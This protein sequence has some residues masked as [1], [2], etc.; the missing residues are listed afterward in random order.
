MNE[1]SKVNN[2]TCLPESEILVT[3]L[4]GDPFK[5]IKKESH[6]IFELNQFLK[7]D[8]KLRLFQGVIKFENLFEPKETYIQHYE[9]FFRFITTVAFYENTNTEVIVFKNTHIGQFIRALPLY[10]LESYG[11]KLYFLFRD[12]RAI[13]RSQKKSVGSWGKPMAKHPATLVHEWDNLF[14]SWIYFQKKDNT[15]VMASTYENLVQNF[16]QEL[17][18]IFR[19]LKQNEVLPNEKQ[20]GKYRT[21]IPQSLWHLHENI[22]KPIQS[23]FKDQWQEDLTIAEQYKISRLLGEKMTTM[24]Y[25][26]SIVHPNYWYIRYSTIFLRF[27]MS[28]III[29]QYLRGS[30]IPPNLNE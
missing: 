26:P 28:L 5:K 9:L 19:L 20:T 6:A 2:F 11:I 23:T 4:L 8:K 27:R 22:T 21:K 25:T 16:R 17:A 3:K 10:V 1:L 18:L 12:P 15:R 7:T 13:Y 29:K 14:Q 24:G 30:E